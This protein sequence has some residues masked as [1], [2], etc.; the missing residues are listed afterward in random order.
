MP[1]VKA[2]TNDEREQPALEYRGMAIAGPVSL[3]RDTRSADV[4]LATEQ[5]VSM[6]DWDRGEDVPE[7]LLMSGVQLPRNR[8]VPL[9]DSHQRWST[10]D[11]IGSVRKLK[12]DNDEMHGTA[13]FSTKAEDQYT[14]VEEG[15]LTDVS[16]GYRVLERTYIPKGQ[17]QKIGNR[18][19]T[20]PVNVVTRWMPKECSVAPI[21]ADDRAKFRD[22]SEIVTSGAE[23]PVESGPERHDTGV[24]IMSETVKKEEQREVVTAPAPEP[25][26]RADD[27]KKM[28]QQAIGEAL[29]IAIENARQQERQLRADVDGMC[30]LAGV[31]SDQELYDLARE[32]MDKV[33]AKIIERRA[34][35]VVE[36]GAMPIQGGLERNEKAT[37]M[38]S[39]AIL[40]RCMENLPTAQESC[41]M[42]PELGR[43][44]A[45]DM[46]TPEK[47]LEQVFA[48][49]RE[50]KGSR[51]TWAERK[52]KSKG[53]EQY[54]RFSL[55]ELARES[56]EMQG[57][58]TRGM[59][60]V[61]VARFSLFP[62]EYYREFG[63]RMEFDQNRTGSAYHV[64][65]SF[66]DITLDAMNKSMLAAY[67]ERPFTW[68]GPM[69][70]G[71]SVPDFK[72][73]YRI[74]LGEFPNLETTPDNKA[75]NQA[76]FDD[77]KESSA[78][79][80]RSKEISYSWQLLI[81]DDMNALARTPGLM[82]N[83]AAR[84]VNTVAWS[85]VTSNP[86]MVD[87]VA[88]FATATGSRAKS[89]YTAS[90][91]G[92]PTR[93]R[94]GVGRKLMRLQVG[95]NTPEAA[96][97]S[98]I[99]N[100]E[101]RYLIVPAALEGDAEGILFGQFDQTTTYQGYNPYS[102]GGR[103]PLDLVVEPLLDDNS[104]TAWYLFA[105]P[106]Q[107]DT[108]EVVFLQGQET[109]YTR[110]YMDDKTLSMNWQIWQTMTAFAVDHRGV[111][112][113]IGTA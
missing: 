61:D 26:V 97:S 18:F 53:W 25:I 56:L 28:V 4:V 101:P 105:S 24:E 73:F 76:S 84:T 82:G 11:V 23:T 109:P 43:V 64:T 35:Q 13:H 50:Y 72:K 46:P 104:A 37:A 107:V 95:V 89:N 69:R 65:G 34:T 49:E 113:D 10:R 66:P 94:V 68:E 108:I 30:E 81:N 111:Y 77:E 6:Y 106:S 9:L 90:G 71:P 33:R 19:F 91:S 58:R 16:V 102:R 54:K 7:V 39:T 8:Q 99:L 60:N 5:P 75:P 55:L 59:T 103:T 3:D 32:G 70:R 1:Q 86:T 83:A 42:F 100:I 47:R 92:V 52:E 88:L 41:K 87:S 31:H 40:H 12:I 98:A 45:N 44:L 14:K 78:V 80:A 29:P 62:S 93:A 2:K 38:L 112:K 21:G 51:E 20:G 57:I 17:K 48:V 22:E 63:R 96:A 74:R 27:F 110:S 67:V 79:E 85:V 15:H 36:V